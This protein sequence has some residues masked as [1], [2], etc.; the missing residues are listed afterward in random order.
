VELGGGMA[1]RMREGGR[2]RSPLRLCTRGDVNDRFQAPRAIKEGFG[3]HIDPGLTP[4]VAFRRP[5]CVPPARPAMIRHR[6]RLGDLRG[7]MAEW[8]KAPVLKI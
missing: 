4:P 5:S 1:A 2:R 6:L 8:F 7:G 3:G